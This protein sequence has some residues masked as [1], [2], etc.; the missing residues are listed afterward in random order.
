MKQTSLE[1]AVDMVPSGSSLGIGGVLL[2]RK[3]MSFLKALVQAGRREL[4]ALT[5]LGSLDIEFLAATG[6]LAEF[7]GGYVGFEHL[8]FAPAFQAGVEHGR[9]E[10]REYSEFLFVSGLRAAAAG[11][12]FLPSKG[13]AGSDLVAELGIVEIADPYA[14]TPVL[15]VP[16]IAPEIGVVHAEVADVHGNVGAPDAA[17]FL[18][19]FD[20]NLAR[21]SRRVIVTAERVV[22]SLERQAKLFSHEV[23]A[24]VQVAGGCAPTALP[25]VYPADIDGISG[26]LGDPTLDRLRGLIA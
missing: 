19:D 4:T 5:F 10:Y 24:V 22:D 11:L 1:A 16:A 2:K 21:A 23:T 25:D 8:G 17:D 18:S 3:P 15:A 13:G 20:V 26:Y 9:I 6:A 7:H 12:P 14:G